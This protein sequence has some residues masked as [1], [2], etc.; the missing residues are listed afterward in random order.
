VGYLAKHIE[1]LRDNDTG[2]SILS[3]VIHNGDLTEIEI[4]MLAGFLLGAGFVTTS[5]GLGKA[6][7]AL[8]RHPDQL[9]AL[10]ANPEGWPNA[11][12]ERSGCTDSH[13]SRCHCERLSPFVRPI[14]R[15]TA[16][17]RTDPRSTAI[18]G[19]PRRPRTP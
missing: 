15:A 5:H 1:R 14:E 16:P 11:I 7:V 8:V 19:P 18:L 13:T 9:A 6:V 10:R 17:A 2:D 3:N 4:R 12:E